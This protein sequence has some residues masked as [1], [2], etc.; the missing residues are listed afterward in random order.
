MTEWDI[1][2]LKINLFKIK[3]KIKSESVFLKHGRKKLEPNKIFKN[4]S[5]IYPLLF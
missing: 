1:S 3:L 2:W 4:N 5:A